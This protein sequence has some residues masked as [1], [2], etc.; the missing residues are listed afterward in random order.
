MYWYHTKCISTDYLQQNI[1]LAGLSVEGRIQQRRRWFF[2]RKL[3]RSVRN[4]KHKDLVQCFLIISMLKNPTMSILNEIVPQS[5]T[6][7]LLSEPE[8]T[9]S[10][11]RDHHEPQ[12]AIKNS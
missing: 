2:P 4:N 1:R 9:E 6:R 10:L 5:D 7:T 3:F 8:K 11:L 12:T